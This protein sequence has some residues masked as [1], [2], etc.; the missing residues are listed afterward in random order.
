MRSAVD[1]EVGYGPALL[2]HLVDAL[3]Q[4]RRQCHAKAAGG[5]QVYG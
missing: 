1:F 3:Q 2:D 5:P 4:S